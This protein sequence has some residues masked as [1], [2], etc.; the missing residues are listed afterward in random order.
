MPDIVSTSRHSLG[1]N[2]AATP[3]GPVPHGAGPSPLPK[4]RWGDLLRNHRFGDW[5]SPAPA[6][7]LLASKV[8]PTDQGSVLKGRPVLPRDGKPQSGMARSEAEPPAPRYPP[9]GGEGSRCGTGGLSP[10]PI[11]PHR[12]PS[13]HTA[14]QCFTSAHGLPHG[15]SVL[16]WRCSIPGMKDTRRYLP[17]PPSRRG[18]PTRSHGRPPEPPGD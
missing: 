16:S 9:P 10:E 2:A 15:L 12:P 14:R 3:R 8:P 6:L 4:R 5:G 13:A 11:A 17:S 18:S 7:F 1:A